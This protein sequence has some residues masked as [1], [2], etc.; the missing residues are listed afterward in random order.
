MFDD[1]GDIPSAVADLQNYAE[2]RALSL[3]QTYCP[4]YRPPGYSYNHVEGDISFGS[5]SD[6][7]SG[8]IGLLYSSDQ[9]LTSTLTSKLIDRDR[10]FSALRVMLRINPLF[11]QFLPT[12][13]TL[14]GYFYSPFAGPVSHI[15]QERVVDFDLENGIAHEHTSFIV[16]NDD[17]AVATGDDSSMSV[18]IGIQSAHYNRTFE[19]VAEMREATRLRM[20]DKDLLAKLFPW[21]FCYG[22]GSWVN[23][24]SSSLHRKGPSLTFSQYVHN[25]LLS[26]DPR[27]AHDPV[28]PFFVWDL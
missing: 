25:R 28:F 23:W 10:V 9:L 26:C 12:I 19:S 17:C 14:Y 24:Y 11:S 8:M 16:P 2:K 18:P 6:D 15:P 20:N 1:Y 22:R 7:Y 5:R 13:A 4:M 3:G 21:L 27:F